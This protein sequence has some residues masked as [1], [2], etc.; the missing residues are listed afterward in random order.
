M[1]TTRRKAGAPTSSSQQSTLS[2]NNKQTR[3][4]KSNAVD[5]SKKSKL[6][7]PAERQVV[8]ISTPEPEQVVETEDLVIRA[9]SSKTSTPKRKSKLKSDGFDDARE[10]AGKVSDAQIKKYWKAEEDSRLAPRST[11]ALPLSYTLLMNSQSTKKKSRFT[12]KSSAT[13]TSA[14]PTAPASA[15]RVYNDGTAPR[16]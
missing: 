13:S 10:K 1:P 3:V 4:T 5:T 14:P 15:S 2:F 9:S 16:D 6:S 8:A 7:E 12:R 11:P